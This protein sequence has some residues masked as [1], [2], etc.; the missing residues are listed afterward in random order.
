MTYA[1]RILLVEDDFLTNLSFSKILDGSGLWVES[2]YCG[3]TALAAIRRRPPLALV[4]DID[5]GPGP[6][7]FDV[8]RFARIANPGLPVV[9]ISGRAEARHAPDRV[10]GSEFITKPCTG[11][12]IVEALRRSVRLEAA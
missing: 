2:V 7:G 6:D 8:A 5:L 1:S 4:T 11:E 3:V 9:F 10:A 12:Q